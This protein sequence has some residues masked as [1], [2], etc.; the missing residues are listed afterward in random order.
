VVTVLPGWKDSFFLQDATG[1][2][3][4]DRAEHGVAVHA[5]DLVEV[6]G[7]S[8]PGLFASS[9]D[10][11]AVRVL[12]I[13]TMPK[14]RLYSYPELEGG[15]QDAEWIEVRGVVQSARQE[16]LW[17][18]R[19]L[20][21]HMQIGGGL[22]MVRLLH[23]DIDDE[24][25]LVD[26]LVRV[27]GVC[28]TVYNDKR[29][30]TGI[31]LFSTDARDIYVEEG[32]PG[33][34]FHSPTN[35]VRS[36][37]QAGTDPRLGHRIKISGI[38]T[39]QDPGRA[40]YLQ[41]G[42]DGILVTSDQPTRV[43]PGARIEAVG[44]PAMGTSS[45]MLRNAVFR[46]V[47]AGHIE[48]AWIRAEDF[49]KEKANFSF[50]QYENQLVR[51][52]GVVVSPL[53]LPVEYAWLLQDSTGD[54][55]AFLPR[56]PGSHKPPDIEVGSTVAVT[57]IYVASV[58]EDGQPR[59]F[60]ILMRGPEDMVV[61]K[62]APWW[63]ARHLMMVLGLALAVVLATT[64][65]ILLLRRRVT[66][67]TQQLRESEERFRIQ[68]Q[69]DTLT[70]LASR[71][72][73]HDKLNEEIS[74]AARS[75]RRLGVLMVDLDHFKQ[76]ND[77]L[78]HHA[79]DEL[80]CIVAERIRLSVRKH[81]TVARMGGDEFVVLLTDLGSVSEAE[82]IGAKVVSTVSAPAMIGTNSML[83]SASVGV[84]TYPEGGP[85]GDSLL[86]VVDAEMYK[87]KAGGRNNFSVYTRGRLRVQRQT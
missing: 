9:L 38:V 67:Q 13:G 70:G 69:H 64:S 55:A 7:T 51:L 27:R 11:T 62:R 49:L 1:G 73:L 17:G 3:S 68:A 25:R 46:V 28:G 74:R 32:A 30:F 44:F 61:L 8:N 18:K 75:G 22:I 86:Q 5:G 52:Q 58:D 84:C 34:P 56:R 77:S 40:L 78:G 35:P 63:T 87:A 71:S 41:D 12:G 85:D 66:Q 50:V 33:D 10:E 79:G 47:G 80:L 59:A 16:T 81:D 21:L 82:L 29:Q 24:S 57:G 72:F 14:A 15:Q 23:F 54:F 6:T 65:W 43:A 76:V 48:P 60:R 19:V 31:R 20:V 26:A 53:A 45:P 39:Y 4:V 2:I 42:N 83:V 36:V 37:M